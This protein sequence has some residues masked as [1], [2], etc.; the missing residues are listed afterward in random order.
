VKAVFRVA[1]LTVAL[2]GCSS[3]HE[4]EQREAAALAK[5]NV[6]DDSICQSYG[7]AKGSPDYVSCRNNQTQ[8]RAISAAAN[9]AAEI[10]RGLT[11][12]E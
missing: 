6:E 4:R 1:L 10:K 2:C 8:V 5:M 7:V 9:N 12:E 11:R 3:Q